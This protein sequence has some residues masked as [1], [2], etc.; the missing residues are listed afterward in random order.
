MRKEKISTSQGYLLIITFIMG[1]SFVITSY[2]EALQDTWA[3]ILLAIAFAT[4]MVLI[5]ANIMNRFSGMDLYQILELVFGKLIGKVISLLYTFYFF[6]IGAL[7]IRS[8]TEYIQVVSFPETPQYFTAVFLGLLIIY[9]LKLGLEVIARVNKFLFPILIIITLL[10][11]AVSINKMKPA[12]LLP[13]LYTGWDTIFRAS[14][15]PFAFP[16]GETV[17]FMT[18]LNAIRIKK[19]P[20]KYT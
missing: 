18:I 3:S 13:I 12:Y 8:I 6:H 5:Y 1:T 11:I 16:L 19:I 20:L 17:V 4:P 2:F 10:T 9:I 15:S 7:C 14:L